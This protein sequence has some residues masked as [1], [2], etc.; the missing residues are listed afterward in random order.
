MV[1]LASGAVKVVQEGG[2]GAAATIRLEKKVEVKDWSKRVNF[3]LLGVCIVDSFLLYKG[4]KGAKFCRDQNSF[5]ELLYE[6]L[7]DNTMDSVLG[8]RRI[9]DQNTDMEDPKRVPVS[10]TGNHL[11]PRKRHRKEKGTST[12]ALLQGRCMFCK[13]YKS[14]FICS[15]C[16]DVGK[17]VYVCH[18]QT[19]RECY[20]GHLE[21]EHDIVA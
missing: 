20:I 15:T 8:K 2:V 12:N 1:A 17:E 19:G 4:G 18:S 16:A 21:V 14:K 3:G 7:I 5:N 10:G 6:E 11:T 9:G 13:K